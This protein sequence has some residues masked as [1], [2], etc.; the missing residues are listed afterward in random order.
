MSLP[1]PLKKGY[2]MT[3]RTKTL[4]YEKIFQDVGLNEKEAVVYETL[5]E[6]GPMSAQ[7]ILKAASKKISTTRPN[8]YNILAVLKQ[9]GLLAEKVKKGKNLFEAESP[10][11]LVNVFEETAQKTDHAQKNLAMVL[12]ELSSLY[13]LTTQKPVVQFFEGIEGLKKVLADSLTARQMICAY[14]DIESIVKYFN[15]INQDYVKKRDALGIKKKS[16]MVDSE[17]ARNYM[18]DYHR[19]TTDTRFIDGKLYPFHAVMQIYDGKIS[20]ITLSDK[21]IIGVIIEDQTIYQMQRSIFEYT[22]SNAKNFDQL[23]DLSKAQ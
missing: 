21:S 14:S 13:N 22:W 10:A 18:K 6:T 4:M 15:E 5:L 12:P 16:I 1:L 17:F 9:K 3:I 20:Y 7:A 2:Y 23:R 11:R 19:N 8:L